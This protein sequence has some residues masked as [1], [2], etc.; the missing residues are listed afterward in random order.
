MENNKHNLERAL[1]KKWFT[2]WNQKGVI[3]LHY[4]GIKLEYWNLRVRLV[5]RISR[6]DMIKL[7]YPA[8]IRC[9]LHQ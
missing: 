4:I 7:S 5:R 9:L 3:Q 8:E 2:A 1:E 6:Q